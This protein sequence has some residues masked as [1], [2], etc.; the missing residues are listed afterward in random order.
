M[1]NRLMVELD[2]ESSLD[3]DDEEDDEEEAE[4]ERG[5]LTRTDD[6]SASPLAIGGTFDSRLKRRAEISFSVCLKWDENDYMLCLSV[7]LLWRVS[8]V[9]VAVVAL[10][11]RRI[12]AV[13]IVVI[14]V[15]A[16]ASRSAAELANDALGLHELHE[17]DEDAEAGEE[18]EH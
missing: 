5:M 13:T 4:E 12:G 3:E 14:I 6:A 2:M 17:L 11:R 9:M 8:G 7:R 10:V 15:N 16:T 1:A 18:H